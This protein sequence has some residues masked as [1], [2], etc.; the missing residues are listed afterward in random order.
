MNPIIN[1]NITTEPTTTTATTANTTNT[2]KIAVDLHCHSTYSDGALSVKDVLDMVH[3]NGGKYIALTDHDSV[4]GI[5]E[6]R[7]YAK[8][9]GLHFISGVEISVTWHGTLIH[10]VGLNIDETNPV[11]TENLMKLR[12]NRFLR[13]QKIAEKLEKLGIHGALEGALQFCQNKD[14][15]SRTHFSRFLVQN[16]YANPGKAFDKFLAPGKP[17]YVQQTWASLQDAVNWIKNS[18]GIAVIAHPSRYKL[19]R[20][21]LVKLIGEFKSY[22]GEGI[23]VISSSHSITDSQNIATLARV[24]GLLCSIGSD[25]HNLNESYCKITV[26]LNYPLPIGCNPVYD[27]L[28]IVL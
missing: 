17:A 9:L 26:G 11:L 23:E 24:H 16:E 12:A 5:K 6:A 22:G 18:G 20:T 27:R 10:I 1:T 8:A 21:K 19:T 4:D 15:L 14:N 2:D 25:F 28:G 13:G 7:E 3:V